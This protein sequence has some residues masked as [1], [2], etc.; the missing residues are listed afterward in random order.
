[1]VPVGLVDSLTSLTTGV[2]HLVI[3]VGERI[4]EA[5]AAYRGLGFNLSERG[6]HTIGS[7][8]HLAV[9]PGHYLE[10]LGTGEGHG[11]GRADTAGFPHGL[12]GLVFRSSDADA[13]YTGLLAREVSAQPPVTFSR[14][15][16]VGGKKT[17]AT[18]DV[19]RLAPK[20]ASFGRVYFCHHRTPELV[21]TADG[22]KHPNGVTSISRIRV[23]TENPERSTALLRRILGGGSLISE[24][25]GPWSIRSEDITLEFVSPKSADVDL[26]GLWA[27]ASGREDYMAILTLVTS[28]LDQTAQVL[29]RGRVPGVAFHSQRILVPPQ[30]AFNVGLE[31]VA[32]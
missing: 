8:N 14:P 22:E 16:S 12:N 6:R 28:S 32:G 15:V 1:M 23:A 10:L 7:V 19:V 30:A 24:Q 3:D 21:W 18:F 26:A 31:F 20:S 2:D 11:S 5:E 13:L 25:S 4:D 17:D 29:Q 9:F 27:N